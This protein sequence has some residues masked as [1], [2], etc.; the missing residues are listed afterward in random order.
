MVLVIDEDRWVEG[1]CDETMEHDSLATDGA[2][3]VT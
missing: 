3:D 2:D 1:A